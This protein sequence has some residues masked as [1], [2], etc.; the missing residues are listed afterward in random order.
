MH[1]DVDW[2]NAWKSGRVVGRS[3]VADYWRRQFELISSEVEPEA[4]AQNADGTITVTVHQIVTDAR[5]GVLLSDEHIGHC[6][7]VEDDLIVHMNV[8]ELPS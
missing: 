4:F 2:P 7:W 3:A 1:P 5:S 8:F 6:Y